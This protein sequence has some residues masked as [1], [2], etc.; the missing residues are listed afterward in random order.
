MDIDV[1]GVLHVEERK[2]WSVA[3]EE[4]KSKVGE[5]PNRQGITICQFTEPPILWRR[6]RPSPACCGLLHMGSIDVCRGNVL[7]LHV[8]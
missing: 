1:S 4:S 3:M 2:K 6:S 8:M 5:F 7:R